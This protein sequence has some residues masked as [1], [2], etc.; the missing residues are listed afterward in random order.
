MKNRKQN[1]IILSII[2]GCLV[3]ALGFPLVSILGD[4][5]FSLKTAQIS[6]V[7]LFLW[8]CLIGLIMSIVFVPALLKTHWG[9]LSMFVCIWLPLYY[10]GYLSAGLIETYF[11]TSIPRSELLLGSIKGLCATVVL[12][13]LLISILSGSINKAE[14]VERKLAPAKK[15]WFSWIVRI[16]VCAIIYMILYLFVGGI[17]YQHFFKS[18]YIDSTNVLI[19]AEPSPGLFQWLIP[20]QLIR[21]ALFALVLIPLCL[22]LNMRR[23]YL[24]LYLG[25]VLYIIGGFAPLIMPNPYMVG[26]LRFYH[27]IEIFFQN[28]PLGI[29]IAYLLSP[30][31]R[32]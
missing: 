17:F 3:S 2:L 9:R 15:P 30:K 6:S 27:G 25:A 24:A 5:V 23:I 22:H 18:F 4:R 26:Q 1:N 32:A 13:Y 19:H 21:G 12:V 31:R 10:I 7:Q 20:L 28:F 11:F 8:Y 29:A 14:K 16:V